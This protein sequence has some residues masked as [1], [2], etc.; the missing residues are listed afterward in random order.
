[1]RKLFILALAAAAAVGCTKD[2]VLDFN[3]E[4][5]GFQNA[6]INN[7]TRAIDPSITTATLT[8]FNVY[9][10]TQGN[11]DGAPVVNI[12]KAV[13]VSGT[14]EDGYSYNI[15]YAQYWING[16]A[17]N[18]AAVVNGTV[19]EEDLDTNGMPESIAYDA[20]TQ[21]DLLY[22][23]ATA[24]GKASGNDAVAFTFDHL[25]SKV[26]FSF[27]NES[28]AGS[29]S[30]YTYKV[31]DIEIYNVGKE[32]EVD[33]TAF[34][35]FVWGTP[36]A[37]YSHI[38]PLKFGHIVATGTAADEAAANVGAQTTYYSNY[39]RL[40]IPTAQATI[41]CRIALLYNGAE[42][43]VT[44]YDKTINVNL[45]GGR[46][47]NFV[48]K[49]SIGEQITFSVTEVKDWDNDHDGKENN[50]GDNDGDDQTDTNI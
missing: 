22:A 23:E 5:I 15:Q 14:A 21:T 25:L 33:V 20:T 36:T 47:Y 11:E 28:A 24:T 8:G 7:A 16:N 38:E 46:A 48:L 1:M 31:T 41:K 10:T 44:N 43:D 3:K 50:G 19:A 49:G 2:E 30:G 6:F 45:V 35:T 9:G 37:T 18:F 29:N 27:Q 4:A 32:A 17:Y 13:P 39:E 34:P 42:V 40:M 26:K 12:F